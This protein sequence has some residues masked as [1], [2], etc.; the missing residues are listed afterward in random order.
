MCDYFDKAPIAVMIKGA[1][2]AFWEYF[3]NP[4]RFLLNL[5]FASCKLEPE[6]LSW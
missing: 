4:Y 5:A 2:G 3:L 6:I 1:I